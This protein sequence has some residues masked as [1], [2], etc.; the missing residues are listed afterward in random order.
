[1]NLNTWLLLL[2]LGALLG[3]GAWGCLGILRSVLD[4]TEDEPEGTAAQRSSVPRR[5]ENARP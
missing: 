4:L 1:M 3:L 5:R 2:A